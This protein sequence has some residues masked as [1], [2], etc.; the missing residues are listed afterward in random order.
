MADLE[1]QALELFDHYADM[2]AGVRTRH[3]ER[4]R[5]TD[6][7][8][9]AHLLRLLTADAATEALLESPQTIL[10]H[11]APLQEQAE[12]GDPRIGTLLG[13][14]HLD[15]VIG[16]GGMGRVYLA[17]RADGQYAQTVAL[18]CIRREATTPVLAEVLRNERGTLAMLEHPNIATLLDGGV[19]PDGDPWFAMQRV[20]GEAID[21]WCDRK[22]LDLR[23][24][25]QLFLQLCEGLRYAHGK[26]ALHGDLKPSNVLVDTSGRPVLLDFGLSS[27]TAR[28]HADPARCVAMSLGYTAPEVATQG[29]SVASDVYALGVLL[30]VLLCGTGVPSNHLFAL[31]TQAPSL[32]SQSAR[33]GPQASAEA[34]AKAGPAALARALEGDLD[35]IVCACLA[36]DP[37]ARPASVAHLQDDLRA[38]L[39]QRPVS[40][41]KPSAA[42]VLGRFLRRNRIGVA[43]ATLALI[44]VTLGIG[45]S[46]HLWDR[47]SRHEQTAHAMRHLFENSFDALVTGGLGQS[48]LVPAATL[49]D[50][51]ASLRGSDATGHLDPRVAGLVLETLARSYTTLGDY[52]RAENLLDEA[53][54]RSGDLVD[55]QASLQATRAHLLNIRSRFDQARDA[56]ALGL[57]GLEAVPDSDR[58]YTRLALEMEL[59]RAQWGMTQIDAGRATL[60]DALV[61]AERL[62]AND[63]RPLASLLIQ[64][65]QW[66]R[67]FQQYQAAI[68]NYGRAIELVQTRAPLIADEATVE[69]VETLRQLSQHRQSVELAMALL[70]RR[71]HV[72][73]EDHPETGRAWRV[74]GASQF[75]MGD[76]DGAA[77]S[78]ARSEAILL[79]SLGE[80]HAETARVRLDL[81]LLLASR[82]PDG[83]ADRLVRPALAV[84]E[85][86]YGPYHLETSRA[87]AILASVLAVRASGRP[88]SEGAWDEVIDLFARRVAIDHHQGI[89]AEYDQVAL[90]KAKLRL[91]RV[92]EAEQE[93]LEEIVGALRERFGSAHDTVHNARFALVEV[94]RVRHQD[95]RAEA[96]L[97]TLLREAAAMSPTLGT[98]GTKV[99]AHEML[100]DIHF[101]RRQQDQAR[102]HWEQALLASAEAGSPAS[103]R[104]RIEN[105]LARLDGH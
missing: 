3:L 43:I 98:R 68:G 105:K 31:D 71:R 45:T 8:L 82:E 34:R 57:A 58:E 94:Y 97:G 46:L 23:A 56:V 39:A 99:D 81:G 83:D 32:P 22:Q 67:L 61:R 26:G 102:M 25:M 10:A 101:Q 78:L 96:L 6:P 47:A 74:L 12:T 75:W 88:V 44:G 36:L 38:W 29:T 60:R 48:P 51:E 4:L 53:Q 64:E 28:S 70:E 7:A 76:R 20:E 92:G 15:A 80:N 35:A 103:R 69:L 73:G 100:G 11:Y 2:A 52:D 85:R 93:E 42:Y 1:A 84:M 59:A 17:H 5:Q 62:A 41:R 40:V 86:V 18:K 19:T 13:P 87:V 14:W 72:L 54:A 66:L 55:Q 89:P 9:H 65:G 49:R 63:P 30:R 27:L 79:A 50:A 33:Q 21:I 95:E 90:I 77:T 91:G 104:A 24:R 37:S 16:A